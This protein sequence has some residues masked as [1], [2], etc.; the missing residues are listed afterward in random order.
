MLV[1]VQEKDQKKSKK[2][3]Q[4]YSGKKRRNTNKFQLL[5]D[6]TTKRIL[7]T[8]FCNGKKHDFQL[9]KDSNTILFLNSNTEVLGDSGYQGIQ[10]FHGNST[11]PIKKPRKSKNNPNPKLTKDQK[12][13]NRELASKRITGEHVIR[14]VK[15]FKIIQE[16]YRNRRKRFSLRV[17]LI[18]GIR[19]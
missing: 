6:L 3:K 2:Q 7:R 14:E 16:R 8:N 10:E 18:S 19:S 11:T 1:K 9:F 13:H 17:N 4:S 5:V 12:K 15:I